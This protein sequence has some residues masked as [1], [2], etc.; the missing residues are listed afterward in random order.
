LFTIN[1][2]SN[3]PSEI[4][5]VCYLPLYSV[6]KKTI[7]MS[8]PKKNSS[9]QIA[10]EQVTNNTTSWVGCRPGDN[11]DV[12]SGQTFVSP[13]EG[14]LGGIEVFS[15]MVTAPG[16][17]MMSLHSFNASEKN[18][19][20]VLGTASIE[21]SK[22]DT[23][24]WICFDIPGLHL[25]KGQTYGFMLECPNTLIGV[26]EAA[27]SHTQPPFV[28]GQEWKFVGKD[29]KGRSFSYFSLAFKVA[30]RA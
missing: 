10:V 7:T 11:N 28:N 2:V 12:I 24:K 25:N 8:M 29:K 3:L 1:L 23:G 26:G 21:L 15:S 30:L 9:S 6:I 18:W 22:D 16:K 20:P 14:D 4:L 13:S 5:A 19:G 27:G 17:V